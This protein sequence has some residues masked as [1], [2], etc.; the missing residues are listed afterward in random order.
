MSL[1]ESDS[2]IDERREK[3]KIFNNQKIDYVEID[4]QKVY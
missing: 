4:F 2:T 3:C 1:D